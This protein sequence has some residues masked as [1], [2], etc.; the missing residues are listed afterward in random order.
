MKLPQIVK[1][2]KE[3]KKERKKVGG[4]LGKEARTGLSSNYHWESQIT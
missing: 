2:K 1:K 4:G 3:R